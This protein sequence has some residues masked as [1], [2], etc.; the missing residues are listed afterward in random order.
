MLSAYLQQEAAPDRWLEQ[1]S[2]WLLPQL[3]RGHQ[4]LLVEKTVT[5]SECCHLLRQ[6]ALHSIGQVLP[7]FQCLSETET[8]TVA[9]R[10][11]C[12]RW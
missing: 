10:A 5:A 8:V 7:V 9:V 4:G 12:F 6:S 1:P 2:L 3:Q 11:A